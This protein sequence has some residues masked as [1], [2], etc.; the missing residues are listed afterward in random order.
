MQSCSSLYYSNSAFW[1]KNTL[2]KRF[3]I[4]Y[5]NY[6]NRLTSVFFRMKHS[7]G[8][9]KS[10]SAKQ[11]QVH[12]GSWKIGKLSLLACKDVV[13]MNVPATHCFKTSQADWYSSFDALLILSMCAF[14]LAVRAWWRFWFWSVCECPKS[15]LGERRL[16]TSKKMLVLLLVRV[17]L[18]P[19]EFSTST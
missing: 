14:R 18:C 5:I 3:I 1:N 12:L 6:H 2:K 15:M 7:C 16:H 9:R 13:L 17:R 11:R 10:C 4:S 8:S 19:L